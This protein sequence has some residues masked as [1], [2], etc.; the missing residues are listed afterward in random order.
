MQSNQSFPIRALRGRH[1][2]LRDTGCA[3]ALS[4]ILLSGAGVGVANAQPHSGL[5]L[6]E[7][8]EAS[9]P[10]TTWNCAR[11]PIKTRMVGRSLEVRVGEESRFLLPAISASGARYVAPGDSETEFW[12][13][14]GQANVTWSGVALPICVQEGTLVTPVRASG[15]EPFWFID[16]DGWKITL[17]EPGRAEQQFTQVE[18]RPSAYG[19]TLQTTEGR[20]SVRVNITE[21]VCQDNMS[22]QLYPYTVT[23]NMNE[24]TH[25]GC[26]GDPARLLQGATWQLKTV[27]ETAVT[28]AAHLEFLADNRLAGSDGCNRLMGRYELSGEGIRFSQLAGTRMACAPEIM[29]Q[30]DTIGRLLAD[31]HRFAF[32]DSG[33]LL[34]E[35]SADTLRL[36]AE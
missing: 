33:A 36:V 11:Q 35:T 26:G 14:G 12:S 3:V 15:N 1:Q 21:A 34:L 7:I 23:L 30:A 25:Q 29:K 13:K 9:H 24:Q 8:N 17:S 5:Q 19:W 2:R 28:V 31:V 32:D 22:G 27:G 16:Y 6:S 10:Y 20:P 4:A 18:Q